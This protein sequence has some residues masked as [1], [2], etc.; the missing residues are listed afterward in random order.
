MTLIIRLLR[1]SRDL[2]ISSRSTPSGELSSSKLEKADGKILTPTA[3]HSRIGSWS[4][5]YG[6][7]LH[8]ELRRV[9]HLGLKLTSSLICSR[10]TSESPDC[11]CFKLFSIC[12]LLKKAKDWP[13]EVSEKS[14]GK[15]MHISLWSKV[16][17]A[18]K[19][20]CS[21]LLIVPC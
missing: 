3:H 5:C 4:R 19:Y 10:C 8:R 20:R 9:P 13:T 15:P 2:I 17:G 11:K 1:P 18:R 21:T 6:Y 12:K 7:G 14:L 16:K